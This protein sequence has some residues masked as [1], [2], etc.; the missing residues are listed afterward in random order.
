MGCS[1]FGRSPLDH[2][3]RRRPLD[4][5]R[6]PRS[7]SWHVRRLP[8]LAPRLAARPF[9][10]DAVATP[11]L[12]PADRDELWQLY[13]QHYDAPRAALEASLGRSTITVR[14]RRRASGELCGM[15]LFAVRQTSHRGRAFFLVWGGA[16]AFDAD[17]RGKWLLERAAL[18]L[19]LQFR[20]HHP[21]APLFLIGECNAFRSYRALARAFVEFWP[22][23]ER[24]TPAWER[25]FMDH[26]GATYFPDHWDAQRRLVRPQ[27]KSIRPHSARTATASH[28]PL[29]RFFQAQNPA[30]ATGEAMLFFAPLHRR[31]IAT[32][33]GRGL[34]ARLR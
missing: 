12:S 13:R 5:A 18:L 19:F 4:T 11:S 27:G 25:S 15:T 2:A 14:I 31:N 3:A 8:R 10:H 7:P 32:I 20:L 34:R 9:A 28:D 29:W 6:L 16:A 22:H 1:R 30:T 21:L 23:P 17:C 26:Y 24:A 33:L